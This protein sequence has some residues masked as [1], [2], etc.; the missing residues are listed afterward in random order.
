MLIL[1]E[2]VLEIEYIWKTAAKIIFFLVIPY[3]L[4]KKA[5]FPFL[6][7]RQ[8]DKKSMKIAIGSGLAIMAVIIGAFVILLPYIDIPTLLTDL[9]DAGITPAVFPFIALYILL[10]NSILEE[11][12][13]RGLLPNLFAKS[14]LRLFLPSFFF[15]IYHVAIFLPWFSPALLV[16]AVT[17]L[18][19]GGIIFQLANE[20]SRTIL[21]SWTIHMFADIGVLLVGVYI[22]YFY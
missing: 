19:V 22:I 13:F 6:K 14:R 3:I 18:W 15:A 9:A 16:L 12:F 1:I 2:Q 7:L 17:G 11:F 4:F 10:G 21:P 20:R 5:G 8:T